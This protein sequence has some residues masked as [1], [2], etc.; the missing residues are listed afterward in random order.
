MKENLDEMIDASKLTEDGVPANT[1]RQEIANMR[2]RING[3]LSKVP[4]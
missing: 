3:E 4:E 1:I 2:A